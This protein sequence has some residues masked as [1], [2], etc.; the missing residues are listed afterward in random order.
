MA[1][2]LNSHPPRPVPEREVHFIL[3]PN[4]DGDLWA[5]SRQAHVLTCS[6]PGNDGQFQ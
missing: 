3:D 6:S 4:D 5:L 2:D 1:H